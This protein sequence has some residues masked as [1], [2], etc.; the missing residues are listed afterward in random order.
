MS[1]FKR[2]VTAALERR[3]EVRDANTLKFEAD[4]TAGLEKLREAEKNR[5][6]ND[7]VIRNRKKLIDPLRLAVQEKV[8][9]EV[10]EA[11]ALNAFVA[12]GNDYTKAIG[13][14]ERYYK[15]KGRQATTEPTDDGTGM[16]LD[17]GSTRDFSD[18]SGDASKALADMQ[19]Q[20]STTATM[21]PA[22]Q[23]ARQLAQET[24]NLIR[25]T[26]EP[27][28]VGGQVASTIFGT[29][30]GKASPT[31][32]SQAVRERYASF[33]RTEAEGDEA[34]NSA[35]DYLKQIRE[36]G[37]PT[38]VPDLPPEILKDLYQ[39]ANRELKSTKFNDNLGKEVDNQLKNLRSVALRSTRG[40]TGNLLQDYV[41]NGTTGDE[42]LDARLRE[43]LAIFEEERRKIRELAIEHFNLGNAGTATKAVSDILGRRL[44]GEGSPTYLDQLITNFGRET[45]PMERS[46]GTVK[47]STTSTPKSTMSRSMLNTDM[48]DTS[49]MSEVY[50]ST[51][52]STPSEIE[53]LGMRRRG[54]DNQLYTV[55]TGNGKTFAI[56]NE[57]G[58][59]IVLRLK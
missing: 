13:T 23:R 44:G 40:V 15:N 11:L 14:L 42:S 32:V 27:R 39:E 5:A 10:P 48:A 17:A 38:N 6:K 7:L 24:E 35:M 34:Y 45:Q 47:S 55:V 29:L 22:Q 49:N 25:T 8:G 28:N 52:T 56:R 20:I 58:N 16:E 33:F 31:P 4:V 37:D 57:G 12:S 50:A 36:K 53:K 30:T 51:D 59:L 9:Q 46:A 54:T 2:A 26:D 18:M 19:R 43:N 1:F 21:T 41:A 3:E